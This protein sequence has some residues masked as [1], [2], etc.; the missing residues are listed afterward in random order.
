MAE[1]VESFKL[2][3]ASFYTYMGC[4]ITC[5]CCGWGMWMQPHTITTTNIPPNLGEQAEILDDGP[6]KTMSLRNC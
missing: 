3:P 2:H 4:L 5:P 1:V 6:V